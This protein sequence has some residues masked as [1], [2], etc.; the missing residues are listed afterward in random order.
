MSSA[1]V[2][3][4]AGVIFY[5]AYSKRSRK[6]LEG[7]PEEDTEPIQPPY[8]DSISDD[9]YAKQLVDSGYRP[10]VIYGPMGI[11]SYLYPKPGGR[12]FTVNHCPAAHV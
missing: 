4:A 2:L 9:K 11:P 3:G 5:M 7:A 10:S 8:Q 6:G 1:L 12:S